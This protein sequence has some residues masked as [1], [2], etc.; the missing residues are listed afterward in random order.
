MNRVSLSE[1]ER[2]KIRLV[3]EGVHVDESAVQ[4]LSQGGRIPLSI[5]EY[6]TTGGVTLVLDGGLYLNAPFD[7]WWCDRATSSLH[8][9]AS[10]GYILRYSEGETPVTV[11]PLPGYLEATDN[12]GRLVRDSAMSH[13]DRVRLSPID[14][15]AYTC[16]FCDLAGKQYTLRPAEQLLVSLAVAVEDTKLPVRHV[17]ISGGT[18]GRKHQPYFDDA[19]LTVAA[20]STLPL[21]VML[22]PRADTSYIDRYVENGVHGFALN[23]EV[24]DDELARKVIPEKHRLGKEVFANNLARAVEATGGE[25]RVR[26]LILAGLEDL[27]STLQ[28]VELIA[29]LGADPVLSPFRPSAGTALHRVEPP[30]VDFLER[31]Y[32]EAKEIVERHGVELGPRCIPCQHNTLTFPV[33]AG[34]YFS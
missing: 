15:C 23:L 27:Q 31:V 14:G 1:G 28:G 8:Y 33:G 7:E 3:A 4:E 9:D 11:L 19:V 5:H 18:P 25:G 2:L 24:F 13:A 26:S 10:R 21:D 17:L 6:A 34:Y 30:G 20:A 12:R 29:G 16:Q 32:L 22:T